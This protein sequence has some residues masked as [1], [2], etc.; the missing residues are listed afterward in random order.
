VADK[1]V[2]LAKKVHC[3]ANKRQRLLGSVLNRY[4]TTSLR[5]GNCCRDASRRTPGLKWRRSSRYRLHGWLDAEFFG[6]R[7]VLRAIAFRDAFRTQQSRQQTHSRR[8]CGRFLS[9]NDANGK[10]NTQPAQNRKLQQAKRANNERQTAQLRFTPA[11]T[12]IR[13]KF[14]TIANQNEAVATGALG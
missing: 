7:F 12:E 1:R 11:K 14:G 6:A 9:L 3:D 13:G 5:N 2:A 4:A 10:T 8:K